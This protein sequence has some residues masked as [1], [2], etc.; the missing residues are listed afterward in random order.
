MPCPYGGV[1]DFDFNILTAFIRL[2]RARP[3]GA[4]CPPNYFFLLLFDFFDFF[5]FVNI[6][7]D[8]N[9][10]KIII[11]IGGSQMAEY[12]VSVDFD[13]LATDRG[14]VIGMGRAKIP[15][16]PRMGFNYEIPLLSFVL[17]EK[18]GGEGYVATCIHLQTDGYGVTK[19]SAINDMLNN[20]WYF[21][22]ENFKGGPGEASAWAN[23]YDLFRSNSRTNVLWDKYHALQIGFA[24]RGFNTDRYPELHEKIRQL[25]EKVRKLEAEV[26]GKDVF[27]DVLMDSYISEIMGFAIVEYDERQSECIQPAR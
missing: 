13:D 22:H 23:L 9:G 16:M 15:K 5:D 17:T 8:I 6:I 4:G 24:M 25:E 20:V 27:I 26:S 12:A 2:G 19:E 21:L 7:L 1:F 18:S 11:R 3:A 14:T 10:L